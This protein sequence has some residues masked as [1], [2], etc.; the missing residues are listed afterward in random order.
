MREWR[1]GGA[2]E[3]L[4]KRVSNHAMCREGNQL[5]DAGVY[6]YSRIQHFQCVVSKFCRDCVCVCVCFE[7]CVLM[8]SSLNGVRVPDLMPPTS[9]VRQLKFRLLNRM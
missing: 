7:V 3:T 8:C 6:C 5:H 1:K 4:G 2:W 9:C